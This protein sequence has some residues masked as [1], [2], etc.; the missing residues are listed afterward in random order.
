[1]GRA[2]FEPATPCLKG[3][4][5]NQTE[6]TAL[7]DKISGQALQDNQSQFEYITGRLLRQCGY[8]ID[9]FSQPG[10]GSP[11]KVKTLTRWPR[12][13]SSRSTSSGD[14]FRLEYH[15]NQSLPGWSSR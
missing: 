5:S 11:I 2:G 1:M 14:S 4:C 6:L 15:Q 8:W 12:Q 9:S 3:R 7:Q 10:R 13:V